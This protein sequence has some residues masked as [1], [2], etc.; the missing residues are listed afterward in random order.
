MLIKLYDF[1][2]EESKYIL[3][4]IPIREHPMENPRRTSGPSS[5]VTGTFLPFKRPGKI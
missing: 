5:A 1:W 2:I 3:S 4:L